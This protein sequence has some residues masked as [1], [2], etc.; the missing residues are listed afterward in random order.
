MHIPEFLI[1]ARWHKDAKL[2]Y[3]QNIAPSTVIP[4]D[5]IEVTRLGVLTLDFTTLRLYACKYEDTY[6]E[7]KQEIIRLTNKV[8]EPL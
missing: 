2:C 8:Q 4:P 7:A 5:V 3:N 1:K 6:A